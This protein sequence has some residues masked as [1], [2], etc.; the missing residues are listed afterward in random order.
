MNAQT[1]RD[2]FWK[3]FDEYIEKMGN[4]FYVTHV[5]GGKNQAAGNI[6]NPS[7]MAMQTICCEYK[8]REN[9]ILV[10]VYIN[11]NVELFEELFAK[12]EVLE[13]QLGYKVEWIDHGKES[14][15]V[16]RIQRTFYINKPIDE[17]IEMIYPYILDFIRVFSKYI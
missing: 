10:Q 7:P 12:K 3:H 4:K 6:N 1:A 11:G 5:K 15:S 16:R 17:M 14:A 8:Y 9:V 13:K 2:L